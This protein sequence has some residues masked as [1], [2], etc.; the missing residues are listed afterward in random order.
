MKD[1]APDLS[2]AKVLNRWAWFASIAVFIVVVSMRQIKIDTDFDF[3]LLPAVYSGFNL[4]T[5]V[6]IL[7][8]YYY[9]RYKK[10][11]KMHALAM[12][13]AILTSVLFLLG[14][15]A[16][17]IT[18]PETPFCQEGSIRYVYFFLLIS[19]IVLAAFI[20]PFI[21]FTYIR[22]L[23]RQFERHRKMARW[24]FPLWLYVALTGP[25]LYLMLLPCYGI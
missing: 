3:S 8:G 12:Q 7:L 13:I 15:V 2:R 22:A 11:W 21:L 5:A 23:T 20:L 6:L 14:Y 19:H 16:Y 24:V 9:I 18:T 4:F 1:H 25:V 10:D 17:H